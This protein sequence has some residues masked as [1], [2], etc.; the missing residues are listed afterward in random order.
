VSIVA[1]ARSAFPIVA[2]STTNTN[3]YPMTAL[4]EKMII[5]PTLIN[6]SRDC[7][8]GHGLAPILESVIKKIKLETPWS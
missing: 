7:P 1:T 3:A 8:V 6:A 4:E 5:A 2:I